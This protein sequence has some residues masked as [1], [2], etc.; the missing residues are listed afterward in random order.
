[1]PG[2]RRAE[3]FTI[4][5]VEDELLLFHP[6]RGSIVALSPTA[7]LVWNLCDGTRT[8]DEIAALLAGAYPEAAAEI[9]ADVAEIL[10]V[11]ARHGTVEQA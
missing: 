8:A 3:G 11:F 10:A 6:G 5:Q 4:E 7:A 1:M 9:P 2:P